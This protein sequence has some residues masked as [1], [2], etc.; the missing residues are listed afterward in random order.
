[1]GGR[2]AWHQAPTTQSQGGCRASRDAVPDPHR[3][4]MHHHAVVVS[5]APAWGRVLRPTAEPASFSMGHWRLVKSHLESRLSDSMGRAW[6]PHHTQALLHT[7]CL[8]GGI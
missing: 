1:M 8:A 4:S 5:G 6:R 7:V 2:P 3:E